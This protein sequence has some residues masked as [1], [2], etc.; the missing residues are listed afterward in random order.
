VSRYVSN[1]DDRRAVLDAVE[2]RTAERIG[3]IAPSREMKWSG[4]LV[5]RV[6]GRLYA[7]VT[8]AFADPID[9]MEQIGEPELH[10]YVDDAAPSPATEAKGGRDGR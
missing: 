9:C 2:S 6:D 10:L 1:A 4:W 5:V 8:D 3:A 7:I